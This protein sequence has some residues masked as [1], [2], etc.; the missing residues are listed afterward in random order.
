MEPIRIFISYSH[1]NEIWMTETLRGNEPNPQ[2]LLGRWKK[3]YPREKGFEFWYDRERDAGISGGD[4]WRERI[5]AELDKA[6]VAILLISED[7]R[8]SDFIRNQELPRILHRANKGE[9]EV[10]PIYVEPAQ[11]EKLDI[12]GIY[13]IT[14]GQPTALSYYYNNRHDWMTALIDVSRAMERVIYRAVRKKNPKPE[15]KPEPKPVP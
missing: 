13:Q 4:K 14:P 15:P 12:P 1:E 8:I 2:Y 6:D 7:F 11:L 10:L 3:E 9:L 5:F